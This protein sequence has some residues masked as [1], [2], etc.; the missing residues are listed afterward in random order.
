MSLWSSVL[1]WKKRN[2]ILFCIDRSLAALLCFSWMPLISQNTRWGPDLI[3]FRTASA[4]TP[5]VLTQPEVAEEGEGGER[6]AFSPCHV[7]I[8]FSHRCLKSAVVIT[9]RRP[10]ATAAAGRQID[11]QG[12]EYVFMC[13]CAMEEVE[14]GKPEGGAGVMLLGPPVVAVGA[15]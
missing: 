11:R 14:E 4:Q 12:L 2:I 7:S 15:Q 1:Q 10:A 5:D 3:H 8:S 13:Q 9:C 6:W